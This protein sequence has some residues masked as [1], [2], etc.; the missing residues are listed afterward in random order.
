MKTPITLTLNQGLDLI[1][2]Y[3]DI[4]AFPSVKSLR[5]KLSRLKIKYGGNTFIENKDIVLKIIKS[6]EENP[7]NK[8]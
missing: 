1:Y 2:N 8:K 4:D 7:K 5:G 3:H 6:V